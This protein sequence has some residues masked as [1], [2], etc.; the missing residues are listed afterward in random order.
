M[1]YVAQGLEAI[2]VCHRKRQIDGAL[3]TE[4]FCGHTIAL[5]IAGGTVAV[6]SDRRDGRWRRYDY[7]NSASGS[8]ASAEEKA[9]SDKRT[10]VSRIGEYE[11]GGVEDVERPPVC[12]YQNNASSRCQA[13]HMRRPAGY[14]NGRGAWGLLR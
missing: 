9:R 13:N 5:Q 7:S 6:G 4:L 1:P 12:F 14:C 8:D 10:C 2:F 11:I 3:H